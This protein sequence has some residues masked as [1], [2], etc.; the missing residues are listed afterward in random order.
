MRGQSRGNIGTNEFSGGTAMSFWSKIGRLLTVD[1][2][3]LDEDFF[4]LP[5]E[6]GVKEDRSGI[7]RPRRERGREPESGTET[8]LSEGGEAGESEA[9]DAEN[10]PG[11]KEEAR[12]RIQGGPRNTVKP[13]KLKRL[14]KRLNSR[15]TP[16][17]DQQQPQ[18]N[19]SAEGEAKD[20]PDFV[21]DKAKSGEPIPEY[22]SDCLEA[23]KE[24]VKRIFHLP[25]NA[26][27]IV[28]DFTIADRQPVQAFALFVEGISD[29]KTIN[30]SVLEPLMLLSALLPEQ[31]E[32]DRLTTVK[33]KLLPGNQVMEYDKW[34]EVLKNVL[35]GST[36]VFINGVGK[37]L[38][39]ETKGWEQRGVAETTTES[40]VRGPHDAFTENLRSN[41][42]LV[43]SRLRSERLITEMLK[44]G[45]VAPTDVAIMYVKGITNQRLVEEVKRR[46]QAVKVDFL[47]DSGTLEQF[48]EDP[49]QFFFPKMLAT[50]RPD[51]VAASL[52]EG[53]VAVFVGQ[54]PYVLVMPAMIWSL[55]HTAEDAYIRYPFGSLIRIIRFLGIWI[56][57]LLPALYIS[58]INY[59]P[60]MFP[61]DLMLAIAT[62]RE[63]VPFP[64]VFEVLMMEFAI[65][66]IR[67][68]GIRIP[69]VIGP[70][71]GIVGALILGQAAVQAGIVSPLLVI[72]VAVTALASFTLPNYNTSFAFRTLRFLFI[73]AAGI[74][75]FYGVTLGLLVIFMRVLTMK[76][77]GVPMV[78]PIA[79]FR[80]SAPDIILRGPVFRHEKRPPILRPQSIRRQ[81]HFTRPWDPTVRHSHEVRHQLPDPKMP[82]TGHKP[83]EPDSDERGDRHD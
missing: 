19:E 75:G 73:F 82:E 41:T 30:S 5:E 53:Y 61:T 45:E 77:F 12:S 72:I 54:S 58:V 60:E 62:A 14:V 6:E 40:V 15:D 46:I 49:P 79:P 38:V 59:H 18:P 2:T 52:M 24:A 17:D 64:T 16:K 37:A 9:E 55:M 3:I 29:K 36:A 13:I 70:T 23:N 68:A 34:E 81:T 69:N 43:R 42:G 71:I 57:L 4:L 11:R 10:D 51:R 1:D 39:V 63:K 20:C 47:Q 25:E 44:V 32:K 67:E 65:E 28:R 76:S 31:K 7:R 27:V 22:L 80:G 33:E 56:A 21:G 48:I 26:D 83:H 66:L 78:S 74:W 8:A 35:G 50:E